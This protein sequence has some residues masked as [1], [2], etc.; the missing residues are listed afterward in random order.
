[1]GVQFFKAENFEDIPGCD[2]GAGRTFC[3]WKIEIACAGFG[4]HDYCL[5]NRCLQNHPP[6]VPKQ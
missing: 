6:A 4:L 5:V 3:P 1:V 2:K